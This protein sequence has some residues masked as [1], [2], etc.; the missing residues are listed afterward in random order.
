M[1]HSSLEA[2]KQERMTAGARFFN[3]HDETKDCPCENCLKPFKT[4]SSLLRH[5]S[6]A[7]E[8]RNHYGPDFVEG[9]RIRSKKKTQ[10][11]WRRA[12]EANIK[13][14]SEKAKIYYVPCKVRYSEVGRPFGRIFK[15]VFEPYME[16]A[17]ENI[18]SHTKKVFCFLSETKIGSLLDKTFENQTIDEKW[19]VNIERQL[20]KESNDEFENE[21]KRLQAIFSKLETFFQSEAESYASLSSYWWE[22]ARKRELLSEIL[23]H[24]MNKAFLKLFDEESFKDMNEK[25]IDFA[26]DEVFFEFIMSDNVFADKYLTNE[27]TNF[28]NPKD[29]ENFEINL[30]MEYGRVH[31]ENL[32]RRCEE[33]GLVSK[34]KL[35]SQEIMNKKLYR[36]D[37]DYFAKTE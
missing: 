31:M 14:K 6:H 37:L 28:D 11:N 32:F 9:L 2:L 35:L 16:E 20:L 36:Y 15:R 26:L 34:M 4:I 23:P 3:T 33:S 12:N 10:E 8:C 13:A 19:C 1:S 21:E 17:R 7:K 27:D 24:A 25:A 22:R 30:A 18:K 5:L 29:F